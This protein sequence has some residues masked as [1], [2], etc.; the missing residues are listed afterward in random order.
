MKKFGFVMPEVTVP[1]PEPTYVVPGSAKTDLQ[2]PGPG[3]TEFELPDGMVVNVD[4]AGNI[5][6][7][8]VE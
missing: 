5:L 4:P 6:G 1:T 7:D 2:N 3:I 8:I